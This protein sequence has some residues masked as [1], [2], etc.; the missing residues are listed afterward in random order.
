[1][2]GLKPYINAPSLITYHEGWSTVHD[3]FLAPLTSLVEYGVYGLSF[4]EFVLAKWHDYFPN[5]VRL[6]IRGHPRDLTSI[7]DSLCHHPNSLPALQTI[8][9]RVT[10]VSSTQADR[11][12]MED[13][14]R[15]RSEA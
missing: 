2:N 3:S 15:V 6:S 12:T 5:V 10:T 8:S 4:S 1:M 9:V 13:L 7:L 11:E 14:V